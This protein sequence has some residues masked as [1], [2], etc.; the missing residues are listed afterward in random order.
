MKLNFGIDKRTEDVN[1]CDEALLG[2]LMPNEVKI[3]LK[4]EDAV[5]AA[6]SSPIGSPKLSDMSLKGKKIA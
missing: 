1:I 4:G 3:T 6:L 5:K 2:V